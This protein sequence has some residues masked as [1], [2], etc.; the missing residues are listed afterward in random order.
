MATFIGSVKKKDYA[1]Y[2]EDVKSNPGDFV[3]RVFGQNADAAEPSGA[4]KV[5][6]DTFTL[7]L[8]TKSHRRQLCIR[9]QLDDDKSWLHNRLVELMDA[10][11]FRSSTRTMERAL[12]RESTIAKGLTAEMRTHADKVVERLWKG[13]DGPKAKADDR[14]G[15]SN[16]PGKAEPANTRAISEQCLGMLQAL[17]PGEIDAWMRCPEGGPVSLEH[18]DRKK[19]RIENDILILAF[20]SGSE[21]IEF[22][23]HAPGSSLETSSRIRR[24]MERLLRIAKGQRDGCGYG[25]MAEL[26]GRFMVATIEDEAPRLLEQWAGSIVS[27]NKNNARPLLACVVKGGRSPEPTRATRRAIARAVDDAM[28]S[29]RASANRRFQQILNEVCRDKADPLVSTVLDART[30]LVEDIQKT[31]RPVLAGQRLAAFVRAVVRERGVSRAEA[32]ALHAPRESGAPLPGR[33]RLARFVRKPGLLERLAGDEP[34]EEVLAV[35]SRQDGDTLRFVPQGQRAMAV[36]AW[37]TIKLAEVPKDVESDARALHQTVFDISLSR[38]YQGQIVPLVQASVQALPKEFQSLT[39]QEDET[40]R[41]LLLRLTASLR[42]G[43]TTFGCLERWAGEA[44]QAHV[45][46]S[47]NAHPVIVA[48][49]DAVMTG[50]VAPNPI[51]HRQAAAYALRQDLKHVL[52]SVAN[53]TELDCEKPVTVYTEGKFA[54]LHPFGRTAPHQQADQPQWRLLNN[55]KAADPKQDPSSSSSSSKVPQPDKAPADQKPSTEQAPTKQ[56]G[57]PEDKVSTEK[58][59]SGKAPPPEVVPVQ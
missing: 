27:E 44:A 7:S 11:F 53:L 15:A 20:K 23:L 19:T 43:N 51:S 21:A 3:S 40:A 41:L 33:V 50:R 52:P 39:G 32:E 13:M 34:R 46:E 29:C 37:K 10:L 54:T 42:I 49:D 31:I 5:G 16:A 58:K 6:D 1:Q 18:I 59:G 55:G 57:P 56:K 26:M 24:D 4:F 45:G 28:Q 22:R 35:A 14:P 9:R 38:V 30:A 2:Y 48:D 47:S 17:N 36:W 25:N 8:V 12:R